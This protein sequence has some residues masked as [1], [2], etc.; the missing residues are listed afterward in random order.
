MGSIPATNRAI[1]PIAISTVRMEK[2]MVSMRPDRATRARRFLRLAA[3]G[4]M[5]AFAMTAAVS[6][7]AAAMETV[8]ASA[9]SNQ[10]EPVDTTESVETTEPEEPTDPED[11]TTPDGDAEIELEPGGVPPLV[12][13]GATLLVVAAVGW[14]LR[15]SSNTSSV[16]D[17]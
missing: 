15:Q 2:W 14:A 16:A 4:L 8:T 10:A 17:D 6:G 7:S 3:I 12:W 1:E 9:L 13:V 11:G 5:L